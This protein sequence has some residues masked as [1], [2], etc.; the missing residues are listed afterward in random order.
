MAGSE[1]IVSVFGSGK[2]GEGEGS[3]KLAEEVGCAIGQQ[4]YV[5]ANGGYNGTMLASAK[6]AAKANGKII[7]VVCS[8]FKNSTANAYVT[9]EVFTSSL[10]ERVKT[11]IDMADAYVVLPGATGTL[12]ELASVWELKNK[13][14][15]ANEKPVILMGDYW[16]GLVALMGETDRNCLRCIQTANNTE[17][18]VGIL[19][20]T[21]VPLR[22]V[23]A[24]E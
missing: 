18:L 11:L 21:F 9:E 5:L 10:D 24:H 23:N 13:K 2:V 14:F 22:V 6:G 15:I 20:N 12:L 17:E 16:Q 7:G 19:Q 3:F 8:A 1:K 4:G